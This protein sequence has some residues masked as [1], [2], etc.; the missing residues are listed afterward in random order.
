MNWM[1]AQV[2]QQRQWDL[3]QEAQTQHI[4]ENAKPVTES[5]YQTLRKLFRN[6][7]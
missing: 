5:A 2:N 6:D 7:E 3:I 4:P 1:H